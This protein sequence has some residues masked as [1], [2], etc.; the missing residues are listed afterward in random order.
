M[1][2]N[3][4]RI[5]FDNVFNV[6]SVFALFYMEMKKEFHYEGEQHNFWEMVY[7][8]KAEMICTAGKNRF[9]LKNGEITFHKP[10]EFHNLEGNN[11]D[12]PNVS[13]I[14]FECNSPAMSYFDGKIFKLN[15]EEKNLL[16]QVFAE[17]LSC[18]EME[19]H[20]NPLIQKMH[21]KPNSPFGCSQSTKNLLELFLIKLY[22]NGFSTTKKERKNYIID[23]VDVPRQIKKILDYMTENITN[24]LT[25]K[26]I[27]EHINASES[28]TKKQFSKYY[29]GGI[30]KYFNN[31]KINEAKRHIREEQMN[32]AQISE[33]L[34][35]DTPQYF[36]KCF[37]KHAKMTPSEYKKSIVK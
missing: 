16:S 13:I 18:Y 12:F 15:Q 10:N 9:A 29:N 20:E 7:I 14:T 34:G 1:D 3:F 33:Y 27:A 22:R 5:A 25:I 37:I 21:L 17:G 28:Q 31:L 8:D 26:E 4:T 35:F 24:K 36:T 23:G 30:I 19:D 2:N 6:E 32:M 11:K